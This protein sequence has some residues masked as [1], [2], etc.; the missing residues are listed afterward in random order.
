MTSTLAGSGFFQKNKKRTKI[1]VEF[2]F[3]NKNK[4]LG[5]GEFMTEHSGVEQ[6]NGSALDPVS[7][8]E[9]IAKACVDAYTSKNL[10][11]KEAKKGF[12]CFGKFPRACI[13]CVY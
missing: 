9:V 2:L 10:V 4:H 1:V 8:F 12:T 11:F 3:N 7:S 5:G 6:T 13:I